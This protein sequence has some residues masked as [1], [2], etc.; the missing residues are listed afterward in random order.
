M[1]AVK[2][3]NG[4]R[5]PSA[6]EIMRIPWTAWMN[7]RAKNRKQSMKR[8]KNRCCPNLEFVAFIGE[9]VGA[10]M[11]L[12]FAL[13]GTQVATS[14]LATTTTPSPEATLASTLGYCCTSH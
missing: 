5:P 9:L 8:S 11:F 2:G 7:S 13:A 3:G 10:T 6:D 14:G 1:A 4:G 12:W